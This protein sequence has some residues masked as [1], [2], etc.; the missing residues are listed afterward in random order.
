M[1]EGE[2]GEKTSMESIYDSLQ[3]QPMTF[4]KET[5]GASAISV[6]LFRV[7]S[8]DTTSRCYQL[9]GNVARQARIYRILANRS[10]PDVAGKLRFSKGEIFSILIAM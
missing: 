8:I 2:E 1:E 4:D 9:S 3:S 10:Y 7:G 5:S 6:F